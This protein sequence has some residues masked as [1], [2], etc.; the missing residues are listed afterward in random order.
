MIALVRSQLAKGPPFGERMTAADIL[1]GTALGWTTSFGLVPRTEE[2]SAYI[3]RVVARPSVKKVSKR[4]NELA[5]AHEAAAK[6][7][8][9][10]QRRLIASLL[11]IS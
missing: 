4:N 10:N 8:R 2:I 6:A 11:L 5:A 3:D 1:W 7:N 9:L